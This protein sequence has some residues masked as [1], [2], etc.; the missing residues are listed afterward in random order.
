[1]FKFTRSTVH[2]GEWLKKIRFNTAGNDR[3]CVEAFKGSAMSKRLFIWI[4]LIILVGVISAAGWSAYVIFNRPATEVPPPPA[5]G[6]IPQMSPVTSRTTIHQVPVPPT[7]VQEQATMAAVEEETPAADTQTTPAPQPQ[8]VAPAPTE[9]SAE[10]TPTMPQEK[11]TPEPVEQATVEK[12]AEQ[13]DAQDS[14]A[15]PAPEPTTAK[16]ETPAAPAAEPKPANQAAQ[17]DSPDPASIRQPAP[18][19]Q[20]SVPSTSGPKPAARQTAQPKPSADFQ[21]TIQVGAYHNKNYAESAMAQLSRKG[22]E[23]YIFEDTDAKS[24]TLYLVR[25]GHFPTRQS[26]Q[27]ALGAYQEKEHK[28]AIVARAGVR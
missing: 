17:Q 18:S 10:Q 9:P 3:N 21:F 25:F 12:P 6:K 11:P 5:R 1:M 22:Y 2:H 28:K 13:S 8:T 23:A 14:K 16:V 7:P 4:G 26:A 27:W 24:R 15:E 20:G 19:E